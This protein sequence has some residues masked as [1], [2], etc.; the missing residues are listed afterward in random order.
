MRAGVLNDLTKCIGC[1]ACAAA[2]KQIN[3]LPRGKASQLEADTWTYVDYRHNTFIRRMCMHC[4]EPTCASVCP[5]GALRKTETGAIT[6]D[7]SRCI[8]CRYCVMACPFDIPKYQW[9]R[10]LPI[11]QKCVLC[12]E[13]RLKQGEEPACTAVC[14]TGATLFGDRDAL[15]REA[16]RRIR[17]NPEQYVP[18][19]YGLREAGGTSVL[20]LSPVPFEELGFKTG[21]RDEAY[22]ELT[23]GVLSKTPFIVS[24]GAAVLF[25]LSWVINRRIQLAA[26]TSVEAVADAEV[27]AESESGEGGEPQ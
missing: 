9:D 23:W 1:G 2:C 21:V 12:Y 27:A 26:L 11:T 3:N 25:G 4:L 16:E 8:G 5:V 14:P 15:I 19:I 24:F 18:H 6:Y 10:A 20:Y 22:P 7:A 13:K 17:E